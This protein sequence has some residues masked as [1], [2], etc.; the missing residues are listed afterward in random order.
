MGFRVGWLSGILVAI[1]LWAPSGL[2]NQP[3]VPRCSVQTVHAAHFHGKVLALVGPP[4]AGK[5]T[6]SP[7]LQERLGLVHIATGDLFREEVARGTALGKSLEPF[8]KE[9][10]FIPQEHVNAVLAK[11]LAQ[12]DVAAGVIL[13]GF[14]RNLSQLPDL[15]K[16]LASLGKRLDAVIHLDVPEELSVQWLG[17][18]RICPQCKAGYQVT[19]R[20]PHRE[21]VCDRCNHPLVTRGDDREAIIRRRFAVYRTETVPLIDELR[22]RGLVHTFSGNTR[23]ES[24]V[25]TVIDSLL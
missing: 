16:L 3:S 10:K 1:C 8:L 15:E 22:R 18:R 2:G 13:D 11:R 17:G 20:P 5:G 4:G 25:E 24:L 19:F 23:P 14:P 12:P 7:M 6:L 9:G 21:G